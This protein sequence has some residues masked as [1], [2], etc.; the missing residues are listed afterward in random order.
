MKEIELTREKNEPVQA[1]GRVYT[2][3]QWAKLL[4]MSFN[5]FRYLYKDHGKT[6]EELY[7]LQGVV[8]SEPKRGAKKQETLR[9]MA[10][11][12]HQSGYENLTDLDVERIP[13]S[14]SHRVILGGSIIGRYFYNEGRLVLENGEGVRITDMEEGEPKIQRVGGVWRLHPDTKLAIIN[15]GARQGR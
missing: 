1:F 4:G 8:F 6:V 7:K 14:Q 11:I 9:R 10:I 5:L 13:G 15:N 3:E 2:A 12:L